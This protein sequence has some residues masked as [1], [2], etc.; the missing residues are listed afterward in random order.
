MAYRT[1]A[2]SFAVMEAAHVVRFDEVGST[3]DEARAAFEGAPLL[4]LAQRQNRG[5]GRH[6]RTWMS[7]PRA[8]AAS[9]AFSPPWSPDTWG[10]LSLVAGLA[11]VSVLPGN[12]DVKWPNDLVTGRGKVGGI[13][14]EASGGVVV[15]GIGANLYWPDP[16][17]GSAA[18]LSEDPGPDLAGEIGVDWSVELLRRLEYGPERWGRAEYVAACTTLGREITW[19]P[20]GRG[21][22]V[23]V[24]ADGALIV[25]TSTGIVRLVAT[26]VSHIR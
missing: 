24:A 8:L 20:E 2:G 16:A 11:G 9:V 18:L 3:Q 22:A 7:A 6:G 15:A 25:E 5:R 14:L 13:L 1:G 17:A 23:N 4:V 26:E 12:P 21:R 19:E 10:R